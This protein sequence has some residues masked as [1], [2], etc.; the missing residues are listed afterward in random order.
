MIFPSLRILKEM[1]PIKN[2]RFIRILCYTYKKKKYFSQQDPLLKVY[3]LFK[4]IPYISFLFIYKSEI[5]L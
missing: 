5:K 2:V 1:L 4:K 3:I